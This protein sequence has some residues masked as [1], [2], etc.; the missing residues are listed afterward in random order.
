MTV[1][2]LS[3]LLALL[4][5]ASFF[6]PNL[7]R[8]IIRRYVLSTPSK[9]DYSSCKY[10]LGEITIKNLIVATEQGSISV[11]RLHIHYRLNF[12]KRGCS[13]TYLADHPK[14]S[15]SSPLAANSFEWLG[16]SHIEVVKGELLWQDEH[17]PAYFEG[18]LCR[19][20]GALSI[21]G[22]EYRAVAHFQN[23]QIDSTFCRFPLALAA[24]FVDLPIQVQ[25]GSF[26]GLL[27]LGQEISAEL[28]VENLKAKVDQTPLDLSLAKGRCEIFPSKE[29]ARASFQGEVEITSSESHRQWN[30]G[31][32]TAE[33]TYLPQS[34]LLACQGE[35][36]H[37]GETKKICME[38]SEHS[39]KVILTGSKERAEIV[40]REDRIKCI[41]LAAAELSLLQELFAKR[42]STEWLIT[43]AL[44][45]A[46]ALIDRG[47]L[48]LSL[49][50]AAD[51]ELTHRFN[52]WL[53]SCKKCSGSFRAQE[54][55]LHA[56]IKISQGVS[57]LFC[58]AE[59]DLSFRESRG[60]RFKNNLEPI[61]HAPFAV[62]MRIG[63]GSTEGLFF[64]P[65]VEGE[66]SFLDIERV[67]VTSTLFEGRLP[68]PVDL[69]EISIE[70][71]I[72]LQGEY[73]RDQLTL[74]IETADLALESEGFCAK[75]ASCSAQIECDFAL[76][77]WQGRAPFTLLYLRDKRADLQITDLCAI[78]KYEKGIFQISDIKGN[79]EGILFA[80][81]AMV[82]TDGEELS[83][84]ISP[85]AI[86]GGYKNIIHLLHRYSDVTLLKHLPL[87]G[88]IA[89]TNSSCLS[90][91][92]DPE[93]V[94]WR[95]FLEGELQEGGLYFDSVTATELTAKIYY[96]LEDHLLRLS[97]IQA[98]LLAKES[99]PVAEEYGLFGNI[100]LACSANSTDFDLWVADKGRDLLRI[101]GEAK[102]EDDLLFTFK[103][104][105]HF[106]NVYPKQFYLQLK[107]GRGICAAGLQVEF[108]LHTI[109]RDIQRLSKITALLL[110]KRFLQTFQEIQ[111]AQGYA[112]FDLCYEDDI[113]CYSL[114][115]RDLSINGYSAQNLFLKGDLQAQ[116]CNIDQLT[117]DEMSLSAHFTRLSDRLKVNF[118]GARYAEMATLGL[119]GELFGESL[120]FTGRIDLLEINLEQLR[121]CKYTKLF[122]EPFEAKGDIR[123]AGS[124]DL[125]LFG[126]D[127]AID[128][129]AQIRSAEICGLSLY[130]CTVP[131]HFDSKRNLLLKEFSAEIVEPRFA[132]TCS[133]L[134]YDIA[135]RAL[136]LEVKQF[137]TTFHSLLSLLKNVEP[138]VEKPARSLAKNLQEQTL[139]GS[140]TLSSSMNSSEGIFTLDSR[141]NKD[142]SLGGVEWT[143]DP[144]ELKISSRATYRDQP[145]LVVMRSP[146][147][148]LGEIKI[149]QE[150]DASSMIF[151]WRDQPNRGLFLT[152][153]EGECLGINAHLRDQNGVLQGRAAVDVEKFSAPFIFKR[154]VERYGIKGCY[155][156]DGCW[157]IDALDIPEFTG[158]IKG[159]SCQIKGCL[160]ENFFAKLHLTPKKVHMSEIEICDQSGS[161]EIPEAIFSK[162]EIKIPS[163]SAKNL[164][165]SSSKRPHKFS[166]VDLT[167]KNITAPLDNLSLVKGEGAVS[168]LV[169]KRAKDLLGFTSEWMSRIGIHLDLLTPTSGTVEYVIADRKLTI[170]KL[171]DVYSH[172]KLAKYLLCEESGPSTVSWNGDLDL[173][174]K[175]RPQLKI[176]DRKNMRI[177]GTVEK[178]LVTVF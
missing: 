24:A 43:E 142:F 59:G 126:P 31:Q 12:S 64:L 127:I 13:F 83:A 96:N 80:A 155:L 104:Q 47:Q 101:V 131:I 99:Y 81:D 23:N 144:Y 166:I 173:T 170:T 40:W 116:S 36:R 146:S 92:L 160:L 121:G 29:G 128:L 84:I 88:T 66:F 125:Q 158:E 177:E 162:E 61:Q 168:F 118:L 37:A 6:Y 10:R 89:F 113:C 52:G 4:L 138:R 174:F 14:L 157:K 46:E 41:R 60:E 71:T 95:G 132:F 49:F 163:L 109:L 129:Q 25:E 133:S 45:D 21:T 57:P 103:E 169:K 172:G 76:Q 53:A 55:G 5:F 16:D 30:I 139:R 85:R 33:L 38:G 32:Y 110:P 164:T 97:H 72:E 79:A 161:V 136:S 62:D 145:F 15:L 123:A 8:F 176:T 117:L 78:A 63:K 111:T 171:K 22:G 51:V 141:L 119:C 87:E 9:I 135:S 42:L 3:L 134:A 73:E 7:E 175:L 39:G 65:T 20:K 137:T 153:I 100:E 151:S 69:K 94:Q 54:E 167:M 115:G 90:M 19:K 70:G 27:H 56:E 18:T 150:F 165:I 154:E 124:V 91:N 102:Q 50:S 82:T 93:K 178:P 159:T 58:C 105:T 148:S 143:F 74:S 112:R 140:F 67:A 98:T 35:L 77:K 11:D 48:T 130:D 44:I 26:S 34:Y 2:T 106:G 122:L 147:P 28:V 1:R 149:S 152:N 17:S 114:A 156:L 120:Q 86:S 107:Q 75:I 68:S 108:E